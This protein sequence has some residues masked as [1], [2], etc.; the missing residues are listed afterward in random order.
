[1]RDRFRVIARVQKAHGR[2]GEVVTV[3][4]HGLPPVVREGLSVAVVPPPLR[5]ERWHEVV[6]VSGDSRSGSLVAL[7]G[8]TTIEDAEALVGA[9]LIARA[10]DLPADLALHD[11]ERLVGRVVRDARDGAVGVI[12]EVMTGPANDVW[13]V[14]GEHGELLVPVVDAVVR[15]VAPEGEIAVTPPQG[16]AWEPRGAGQ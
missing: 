11:P 10:E 6:S 15:E 12:E 7:S 2:R 4:V 9:Y 8:V 1:M 5:G 16:L 14:R 3:P 13:V